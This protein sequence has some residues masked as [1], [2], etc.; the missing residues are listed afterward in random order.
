MFYLSDVEER[1]RAGKVKFPR[2][3]LGVAVSDK[4][5]DDSTWLREIN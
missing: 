4:L 2:S 3:G 5:G 1:G